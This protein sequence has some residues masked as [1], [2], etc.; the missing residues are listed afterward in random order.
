MFAGQ[1]QIPQALFARQRLQLLQ[2]RRR[3]VALSEGLHLIVVQ[4]LR[5]LDVSLHELTHAGLQGK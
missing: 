4:L 2:H 1:E 3:P 5:R